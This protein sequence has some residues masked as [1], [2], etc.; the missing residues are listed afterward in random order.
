MKE[1]AHRIETDNLR[2]KHAKGMRDIIGKEIHPYHEIFFFI[3]GEAK[4]TSEEG[5]KRLTPYTTVVIPKDTF[6]SFHVQS[7]EADYHRCVLNF[8]AVSGL[9]SLIDRKMQGIFL[10]KG[11]KVTALFLELQQ[12]DSLPIAEDEKR[13][14]L[15]ALFAQLLVALDPDAKE[16]TFDVSAH[17]ITHRTLAYINENPASDLSAKAL[18]SRLHL[19]ESHLSHIFKRDLHIPLH[20]YVLKKRLALAN[21]KIKSGTPALRAAEECGFSDYSGFYKQYK[22][23][24]GFSPAQTQ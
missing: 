1:F 10:T 23:L 7:A 24:F 17:P 21:Q 4:F 20:K 18:A 19:S 6:H 22:K 11:E 8:E 15:G 2:F 14:L 3:G 9:G 12:L 5:T 16:A 13:I